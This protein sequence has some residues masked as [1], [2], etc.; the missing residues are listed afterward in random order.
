MTKKK[1]TA[2]AIIIFVLICGTTTYFIIHHQNEVHAQ[3]VAKQK[4]EESLQKEKKN[5]A[6]AETVVTNAFKTRTDE[7]I[8]KADVAINKLNKK[9]KTDK[10]RLT[11]EM[12]KLKNWLVLKKQLE[13][14][15]AKAEKSKTDTDINEVQTLLKTEVDDRF[16][17]EK[18]SF[19]DRLTALQEE[20]K[21]AKEEKIQQ[22]AKVQE[23]AQTAQQ[24]ADVGN[25]SNQTTGGQ[26]TSYPD[27]YPQDNT[28]YS[29]QGSG[30]APQGQSPASTPA[31]AGG[32]NT[33]GGAPA[34]SGNKGGV[35]TDNGIMGDEAPNGG[36]M[37]TPGWGFGG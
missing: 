6:T 2:I 17:D 10:T 34:G 19:Q 32:G 25:Q 26:D 33:G 9:Q 36:K 1:I 22:E 23:E 11:D 8:E 30:G 21:K 35:N 18:Q 28:Q 5:L 31:P 27:H 29:A 37:E 12:N 7:D 14:A 24:Q 15:T 20:R 3:E 4:K 16:K 13:T